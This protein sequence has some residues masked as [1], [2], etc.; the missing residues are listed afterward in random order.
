MDRRTF[1]AAAVALAG[2]RH[3][4][5]IAREMFKSESSNA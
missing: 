2:S 4:D 5:G 3:P 1:L